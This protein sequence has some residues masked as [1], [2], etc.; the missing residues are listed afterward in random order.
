MNSKG[1]YE[2]Y[3]DAADLLKF[4]TSSNVRTSIL[5]SLNESSKNLREL[6]R[7]LN[8]ESSTI[9]HSTNK[10]EKR[11]FIFKTGENYTLSQTGKIF[12]LKLVNLIKA[13]DTVKT[14]EKL[15]L[16]HEIDGIPKDLIM[17]IGDLNNSSLIE[18]VPTA[19]DKVHSNFIQ[20]LSNAKLIRGV[21]PILHSD[22]EEII[23]ALISKG[24]DIQLILTED[25]FNALTKT[26]GHELIKELISKDNF[27]LWTIKEAKVAFTV[28]DSILS[29][30][31]FTTYG[32]YDYNTDLVSDDKNAIQW[33][34]TLFEYYLK[35]AKKIK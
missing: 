31:F 1:I 17:K 16:H 2:Q 18:S 7:E 12:T 6:K 26:T 23:M 5:L 13:E 24:L 20:L 21:S 14:Y 32:T 4:L 34:K 15:W 29:L 30:G 19:I 8:L 35:K 25:V 10:L 9:I 22:F 3:D 11:N 33:G 27:S 28:T